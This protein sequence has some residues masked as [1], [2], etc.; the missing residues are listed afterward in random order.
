MKTNEKLIALIKAMGGKPFEQIDWD[1]YSGCK[2]DNPHIADAETFTVIAD[3]DELVL[4][5]GEEETY[6]RLVCTL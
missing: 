3:G 6:L 5:E 4:H 1:C 2:S